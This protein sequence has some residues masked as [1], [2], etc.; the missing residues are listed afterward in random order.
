MFEQAEGFCERCHL[1][2]APYADHVKFR[3]KVYHSNCWD[4]HWREETKSNKSK[5][6]ALRKA[7]RMERRS[8]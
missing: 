7:M 8:V 3:G 1:R 4:E 2:V 6:T 5:L